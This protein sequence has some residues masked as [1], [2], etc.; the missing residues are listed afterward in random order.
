MLRQLRGNCLGTS[1]CGDRTWLISNQGGCTLTLS[2]AWIR[3]PGLRVP[4]KVWEQITPA[5]PHQASSGQ[6]HLDNSLAD[7]EPRQ[8]TMELQ[9]KPSCP[10]YRRCT[11]IT[12]YFKGL[13][14]HLS[15]VHLSVGKNVLLKFLYT[16]SITPTT[17]CL[18][19]PR[20]IWSTDS[21]HIALRT[22]ITTYTYCI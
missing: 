19:Y 16:L 20:S 1:S 18:I 21:T 11:N 8:P 3:T 22:L 17:I 12:L 4:W 10:L 9:V 6:W 2:N 7:P 15:L 14:V 5:H 13:A